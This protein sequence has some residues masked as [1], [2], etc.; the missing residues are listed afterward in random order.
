MVERVSS[1]I[2]DVGKRTHGD[3]PVADGSVE[4]ECA[5]LAL[6]GAQ[7]TLRD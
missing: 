7:Y 2:A 3:V 5:V 6:D 4:H 1:E